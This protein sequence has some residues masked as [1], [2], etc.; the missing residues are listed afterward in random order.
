MKPKWQQ[1]VDA[2]LAAG[3]ATERRVNLAALLAGSNPAPAPPPGKADWRGWQDRVQQIAE[4]LG[5]AVL[6]IRP[7]RVQRKDGTVY[8][9]TPV[10]GSGK[11]FPDFLFVRERL[12]AA[13]VKT[14]KGRLSAEQ[15]WWRDRLVA[16]GVPWYEWRPEHE[17][18]LIGVLT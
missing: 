10:A 4:G 18:E 14:G 16:A 17:Q 13:E 8:Y 2:A 15:K 5:W 9:E 3:E 1:D 7:V 11:G 6:V 12:V